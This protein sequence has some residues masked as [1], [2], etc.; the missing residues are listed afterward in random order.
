MF[1]SAKNDVWH[2]LLRFVDLIFGIVILW[3]CCFTNFAAVSVLYGL[4]A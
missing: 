3:A 4:D 2:F 1:F